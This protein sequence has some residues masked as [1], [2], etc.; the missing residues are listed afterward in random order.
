MAE[1][2]KVS[3][4]PAEP[5]TEEGLKVAVTPAGSVLRLNAT[6]PLK[7]PNS[8]TVTPV[9]AVVP[10][11]TLTEGEVAATEKP[12]PT[13]TCGSAFCTSIVKYELQ[14]VPAEG[15]FATASVSMLLANALE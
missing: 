7:V 5:V 8:L 4:L 6:V 12:L 1:A 10:C 14:N 3:V 2:V 9:V 15:E 13:G 11:T